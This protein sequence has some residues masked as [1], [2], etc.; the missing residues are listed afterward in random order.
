MMIFIQQTNSVIFL[1]HTNLL[2][3]TPMHKPYAIR[4]IIGIIS[5]GLLFTTCDNQAKKGP[6]HS[7]PTH[8]LV[9]PQ[10]TYTPY[11]PQASDLVLSRSQYADQLYAF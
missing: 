9:D 4:R 1:I 6:I 2:K 8:S 10:Q 7:P 5:L 11:T 3:P